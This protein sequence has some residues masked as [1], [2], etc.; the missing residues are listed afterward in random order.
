LR[1]DTVIWYRGT[2]VLE[3]HAVAFIFSPED[4]RSM[5]AQNVSTCL[6]NCTVLNSRLP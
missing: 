5:F 4:G 6:Q 1:G 3:E 2:S